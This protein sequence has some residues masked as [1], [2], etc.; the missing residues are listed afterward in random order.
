MT[1]R[2]NL[3]KLVDEKAAATR[4]APASERYFTLVEVA[5]MLRT[6]LSTVRHWARG[7]KLATIKPGRHPLVTETE[8]NRFVLASSGAAG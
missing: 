7:G 4:P 1:K 2:R 5:S 8:F 6:N 3:L